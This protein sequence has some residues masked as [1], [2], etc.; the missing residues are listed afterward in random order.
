MRLWGASVVAFHAIAQI[1]VQWLVSKPRIMEA[2]VYHVLR[3]TP[4]YL[5]I[6]KEANES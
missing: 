3:A 1:R 5:Y 6:E 2:M 4:L